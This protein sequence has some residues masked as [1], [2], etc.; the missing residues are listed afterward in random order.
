MLAAADNSIGQRMLTEKVR[1]ILISTS[2]FLG[3]I[4][5]SQNFRY[6]N[7][8]LPMPAKV[9]NAILNKIWL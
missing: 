5:F 9:Q 1:I 3:E 6:W 7:K 4:W 8:I 2:G